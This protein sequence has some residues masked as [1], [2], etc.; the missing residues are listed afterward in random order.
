M[1][2]ANVSRVRLVAVPALIALSVTLLRLV[3]ELRGWSPVLFSREPGGL[4]AVVGIIWLAPI[5]GVYFALRLL[6]LGAGPAT[7]RKA[8]VHA[9]WAAGGFIV[10]ALMMLL[11]WPPFQVQVIA[12]A[13]VALG[14]VMLQLRGWPALGQVLLLYAL[15]SRV[16]VAIVML[17]A[18]LGSWGTH[19]DAFPPGFPL[20]EP[21][22][23]WLWGGLAAQ[24]TVWVGNTVLLGALC[25]S[26]TAAV[27]LRRREADHGLLERDSA[28]ITP[29]VVT[30]P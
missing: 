21:L 29:D 25:G 5:F 3:G 22:E 7:P 6:K 10:F 27:M 23:K 17:F 11:L 12:I 4:G 13:A 30:R 24:M 9:L 19:Y 26:V 15:A 8:V 28:K 2:I 18:I 14:V 16:P 20:A 1:T